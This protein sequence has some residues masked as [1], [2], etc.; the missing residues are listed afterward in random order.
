MAFALLDLLVPATYLAL[1]EYLLLFGIRSNEKENSNDLWRKG[2]RMG[3]WNGILQNVVYIY[4]FFF[5]F[6]SHSTLAICNKSHHSWVI[7]EVLTEE[8]LF[9]FWLLSMALRHHYFPMSF[10]SFG[11]FSHSF[12]SSVVAMMRDWCWVINFT[13]FF[14]EKKK[15][16]LQYELMVYFIDKSILHIVCKTLETFQHNGV[17]YA[18]WWNAKAP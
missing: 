11:V 1:S 8:I 6:F 13:S 3:M 7:T 10:V 17:G 18:N 5:K 9:H 2:R 16:T 15:K 14:W 4:I 12:F